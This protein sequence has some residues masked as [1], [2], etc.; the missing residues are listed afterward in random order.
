MTAARPLLAAAAALAAL[1]GVAA[2]AAAGAAD[3][4]AAPPPPLA[5]VPARAGV[6]PP[7]QARLRGGLRVVVLERHR[8]PVVLVRLVLPRGAV[9]DPPGQAGATWLAVHLLTDYRE[10]GDRGERL[11]GEK[12]LRREAVE[13]GGA[14]AAAVAPD[15]SLL[16]VSGYAR[17][18]ARYLALLAGAVT[19]P[20][21]GEE[22]F[23]AR[24]NALLDAIEDLESSDAEALE[25]VVDQAAFGAG[26]PYARSAAGTLASLGALGLEDVVAQQQAVLVPDGATLLVVGDVQADRV[27]A[28]VRRTF[29]AWDRED[30]FAGIAAHG[31]RGA[32]PVVPPPAARPGPF[33]VGLLRRRPASTLLACATRPLT[34]VRATDGA[35]QVF[36]ALL[37]GGGRS[38]LS[39]ALREEGGFTYAAH[40]A[41]VRRRAARA[42]VACAP[43]A[44]A[45]AEEGLR[46]FRDALAAVRDRP[47]GPEELARAKAV[48]LAALDGGEEDAVREAEAWTE[49]IAL[50][51]PAPRGA[52]E[53]AE[54]AA[55]TG[56]DVRRVAAAALRPDGLRWILSG[57]PAVAARAVRANGLGRL[58]A[59]PLER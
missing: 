49:A 11:G 40:A 1:A 27:I 52:R 31:E 39:L 3:L 4:P 30:P 32:P 35:L 15:F 18:T 36:A 34:G 55:T 14:L 25:R 13:L 33:E 9:T 28:E 48:R 29:A 7:A 17:D 6:P 10:R 24:R 42:L 2:P 50:G 44:A 51:D 43:L 57:D 12:P 26:H 38:R 53:A 46:A 23:A 8:R 54:I 56:E 59:L 37:G 22:S 45:R 5:R 21:H 16:S 58:V 41:I 20:R 19:A 47:P